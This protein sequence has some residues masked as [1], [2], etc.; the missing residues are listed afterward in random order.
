MT[1]VG[2]DD[3]RVERGDTT[4]NRCKE[5]WRP[6]RTCAQAGAQ[7]ILIIGRRVVWTRVHGVGPQTHPAVQ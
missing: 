3:D 2:T 1:V 7:F 6:A 4:T 5:G